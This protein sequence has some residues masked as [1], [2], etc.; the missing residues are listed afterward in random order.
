MKK[1]T[2]SLEMLN[3]VCK[4]RNVNEYESNR[5]NWDRKPPRAHLLNNHVVKL[6]PNIYVYT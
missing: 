4:C 6:L 5:C 3:D 2:L 1:T